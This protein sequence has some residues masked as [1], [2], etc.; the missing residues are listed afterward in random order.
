MA[1]A[2]RIFG[3]PNVQTESSSSRALG[4]TP[5][6]VALS[7]L[8][9]FLCQLILQSGRTTNSIRAKVVVGQTPVPDEVGLRTIYALRGYLDY[10][11]KYDDRLAS[12]LTSN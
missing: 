11:R 5:T 3:D 4:F 10:V 1:L 6:S 12:Y 9:T 2:F 8:A 7:H